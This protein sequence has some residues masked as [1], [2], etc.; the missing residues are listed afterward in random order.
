MKKY[1]V[2]F[3]SFDPLANDFQADEMEFDADDEMHAVNQLLDFYRT[4]E[5]R[6]AVIQSVTAIG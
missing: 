4:L 2:A 6:V 5:C 1:R 3:E